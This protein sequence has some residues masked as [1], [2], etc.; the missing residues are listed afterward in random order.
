LTREKFIVQSNRRDANVDSGG[1]T[2][3]S[4]PSDDVSGSP[5]GSDAARGKEGL[6]K[7]GRGRSRSGFQAEESPFVSRGAEVFACTIA[8]KGHDTYTIGAN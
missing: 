1:P 4:T 3:I 8:H 6:R 7:G 5:A 2:I